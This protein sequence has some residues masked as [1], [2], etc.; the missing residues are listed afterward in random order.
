M[1]EK[2]LEARIRLKKD[3]ASNWETAN[4][5]LLNGEQI[6][7][8][9]AAGETRYKVGDGTKTYTQLPFT[10]EPL[11]SLVSEKSAVSFS[12]TLTEGEEIGKITINGTQTT[13]FGPEGGE[14]YGIH[15]GSGNVTIVNG[16]GADLVT[17]ITPEMIGA[18]TANHTH[19]SFTGA[20]S[21]SDGTSGFVPAPSLGEQDKFLRGDGTWVAVSGGGSGGTVTIDVDGALSSTSEN[22][23]Q[24]KVINAALNERVMLKNGTQGA[25]YQTVSPENSGY[26][27]PVDGTIWLGYNGGG[28]AAQKVVGAVWNDYAEFLNVVGSYEVGDIISIGDNDN[29]FKISSLEKDNK[30]VGVVSNTYF[31]C[32]GSEDGSTN[33][34]VGLI[35]RVRVNVIGKVN[36][37]DFICSSNLPGIG[38]VLNVD[39]YKPGIIVGQAIEQKTDDDLGSVRIILK[40]C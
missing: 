10:D 23:V 26:T 38:R 11:R 39:E 25:F 4:P 14:I 13:I 29:E 16:D 30:I 32:T 9:T 24:N 35:G 27:A 2:V 8:V 36:I 33:V 40:H 31:T 15:D 21:S 34:P 18:A 19:D 17:T 1:A 3:T 6:I 28:I 37:G 20:T 5:V 7:V 12:P 22:P